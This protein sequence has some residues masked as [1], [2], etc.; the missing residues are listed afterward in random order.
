MKE[1]EWLIE[2]CERPSSNAKDD[3]IVTPSAIE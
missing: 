3:E 1:P 2:F